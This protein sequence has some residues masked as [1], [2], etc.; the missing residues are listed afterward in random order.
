[1]KC[2]IFILLACSLNSLEAQNVDST[3]NLVFV[4]PY[5]V[6]PKWT[7]GTNQELIQELTS[8]IKFPADQC[9][10]GMAVLQIKVD[11]FG[12]VQEPQIRRSISKEIDEQLLNIICDFKFESGIYRD[13]KAD[14]MLMLP[15]R[16]KL[17]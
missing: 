9:I 2:V 3:D 6:M 14:C 17:E 8:G 16:I 4:T 12:Q 15:I 10:Q 11:T 5:Q 7:K 1:M 13:G